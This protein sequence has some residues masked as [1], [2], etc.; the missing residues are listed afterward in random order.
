MHVLLIV[1]P[2]SREPTLLRLCTPYF[3][4]KS[5]G[6]SIFSPKRCPYKHAPP[7]RPS[8]GPSMMQTCI[9]GGGEVVLLPPGN[10]P[11][12]VIWPPL[13]SPR[14]LHA[15][16]SFFRPKKVASVSVVS[17]FSSNSPFFLEV[18]SVF[19][20]SFPWRIISWNPPPTLSSINKKRRPVG[21]V[22]LAGSAGVALCGLPV[23]TLLTSRGAE[24]EES[25]TEHT[26]LLR[27]KRTFLI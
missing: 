24:K 7:G 4:G 6:K 13:C 15:T 22:M 10:W 1:H 19:F 16:S 23:Y 12:I 26:H 11:P 18:Y 5:R 21:K 27:S 8:G 20:V 14:W 9:L 3:Y 2:P 17:H 25:R